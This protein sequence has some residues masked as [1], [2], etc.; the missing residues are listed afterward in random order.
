[1]KKVSLFLVLVML[2]TMLSLPAMAEGEYS[3]PELNTT[4]PITVTF[5][6][7][8]D[9]ELTQALADKFMEM[10]P[11]IT[12]ELVY[13]TTGD[14]SATLLNMAA[15]GA[16][17]DVFFWLDLDPL[18]SNQMMMD[19]TQ[20]VENDEEYMTQLYPS[21]QN[22]GY[23]DGER[24][25]FMPGE[26]LPA[27]V[28]LDK[29]VFDKLNVDMPGQDWTWE[30]MCE[31]IETMSD[32]SQGIWGYNFFMGPVTCGPL[33][34]VDNSKGEF[35][36]NGESYDFEVW[37]ECMELQSEYARK[38]YQALQGSD[39][40][41][42]V[43]P[44]NLWPGESGHVAIQMDAYWTLNNIYTQA[45]CLERGVNMVPYN[46]PAGEDVENAGRFSWVDFISI[47]ATCEHP[48]EAYEVAKFLTWGKD[49][50]LARAEL[51][52]TIMNEAGEPIYR[53]PG[54]MPMVADDEVI[55]AMAA[56]MPELKT[57]AGDVYWY[58][59]E[60]FLAN[61]TNPVTFGGRTIPGFN[62]FIANYYH[63]SD[64]NGYTGIESAIN[65]NAINLWDYV[66]D[67]NTTGREYY[68]QTMEVFFSVYGQP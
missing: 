46:I 62:S 41:L 4:D 7:W 35:G 39:E 15:E 63:G 24:C 55:A 18:L 9:Y 32:P 1:M 48:R 68:D 40:Y 31:L 6:T 50:W 36:W 14:V 29:G 58:D 54:S 28:Y 2:A 26:N 27:V 51:Y 67:L 33:S 13:T 52:P 22:A 23:V 5:M 45:Y 12:I 53:V 65:A 47:S 66:D 30:E 21:L 38:G 34:L 60:G 16:L 19:I 44:D 11:N 37:A 20:L 59:W 43:V 61:C 3:M 49:G 10:H 8:D 56:I 57:A 25:F 64:F 17:P 42:A